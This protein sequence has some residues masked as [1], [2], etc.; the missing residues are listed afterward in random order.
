[1]R[2]TRRAANFAGAAACALLLGYAYYTQYYGGLEP[3]PL[4]VFQRIAVFGVGVVF[5]LAA[6]HNPA[7][8]GAR[9][10]A[11]LLA[12]VTLAGIGVAA[13]HLYVQSLPPGTLPSCGAPLGAL[14]EVLPFTEVIRKVLT[15]S[16]EC[17]V[18]NWRFLGLSMPGWVLIALTGFGA[19]ALWNNLRQDSSSSSVRL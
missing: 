3:C 16:G 15:A 4:C 18:V 12:L 9:I 17:A 1:M 5:L 19:W 2:L 11:A 10:Y 8:T 6:L 7:R 13:R 14:F